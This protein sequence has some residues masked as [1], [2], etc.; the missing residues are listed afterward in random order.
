MQVDRVLFPVTALG[1]GNRLGMWMIGCH[2]RCKKCANPELQI[3]DKTKEISVEQLEEMILKTDVKRI[4]GITIS[5]GEPFAQ[6]GE[7]RKFL[8]KI[9]S[10][11]EDILVFSGYT[12]EELSKM[13]DSNV[14]ECFQYIGV[15]ISGEY[16]DEKN[17]NKTAL[18]ASTNQ[19]MYFFKGNLKGK[20][21]TYM[22]KGRQIQNVY[23]NDELMSIGIHNNERSVK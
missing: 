3:F 18:I 22:N 1:P 16:I 11:I 6:P 2:K 15:L 4:E 14:Q 12:Y 8:K 21:N 23:F 20:Y 7:L 5:G 17:D 13:C 9:S 10:K 19:Q